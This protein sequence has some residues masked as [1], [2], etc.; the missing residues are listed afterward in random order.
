MLA[1]ATSCSKK[2]IA[3]VFIGLMFCIHAVKFFHQHDFFQLSKNKD[4]HSIVAGKQTASYIHCQVCDFK[5]GGDIVYE[6]ETVAPVSVSFT[7]KFIQYDAEIYL[8]AINSKKGRGPP[9]FSWLMHR[10][11]FFMD[12]ISTEWKKSSFS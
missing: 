11:N 7:Y 12:L 5:I 2:I 9:A 6:L 10:V 1:Y 4:A 8:P 3:L